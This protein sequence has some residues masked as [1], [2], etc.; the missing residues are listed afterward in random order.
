MYVLV[1]RTGL[2]KGEI[3]SLTLRSLQLGGDPPTAMVEGL[4]GP[5][6]VHRDWFGE[7]SDRCGSRTLLGSTGAQFFDPHAARLSLRFSTWA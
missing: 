7:R 1:A 4:L 5:D 3:G 6:P 2:R